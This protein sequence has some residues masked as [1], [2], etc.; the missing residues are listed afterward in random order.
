MRMM[1]VSVVILLLSVSIPLIAG[2]Q[3]GSRIPVVITFRD[4][5]DLV[6]SA[7]DRMR[8]DWGQSYV[9]GEH[10]VEAFLGTQA[11]SGNV[12]LRLN[13]SSRSL[14]LDFAECA[15][16]GSCNPPPSQLYSLL[17]VRV[18]ATAVRKNGILGMAVNETMS[19]PARI[20]YQLTPEQGPGFIDFN[21]NLSGK[22]PCKN[23]SDFVSVTRTGEGSWVIRA[24]ATRV[25][26]VTLPDNGG[27]GGNYHFPFQF[28]VQ[29]K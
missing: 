10:A 19:A 27:W 28:T 25:A 18:D 8:S 22:S 9:D 21:P 13:Q 2:N 17:F 11:S 3:P 29:K 1:R 26:C 5:N 7:M 4:C 14:L 6:C 24:D 15:S 12:G 16:A 20:Y 23:A